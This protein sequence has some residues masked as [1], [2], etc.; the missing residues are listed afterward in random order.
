MIPQSK[1]QIGERIFDRSIESLTA[2]LSYCETAE[3]DLN[4]EKLNKDFGG[5][6]RNRLQ[7]RLKGLSEII[8]W[9]FGSAFRQINCSTAGDLCELSEAFLRE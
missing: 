7:L 1:S 6:H 9:P 2:I 5:L 4:E 3:N 8:S